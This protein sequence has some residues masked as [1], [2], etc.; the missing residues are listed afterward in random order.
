MK[1]TRGFKCHVQFSYID[2]ASKVLSD[3]ITTDL[4]Q[5]QL[6]LVSVL[7]NQPSFLEIFQV[8][9]DPKNE[10]FVFLDQVFTAGCPSYHPTST[11]RALKGKF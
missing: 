2:V 5:F 11:V 7:H 6:C 3:A 10:C 1:Y 8:R 4:Q 9:I